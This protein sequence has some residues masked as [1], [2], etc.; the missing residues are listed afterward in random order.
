MWIPKPGKPEKR[1]LGIST[2]RDRC[3][4]ALFKLALEPEWEAIPYGKKIR[5]VLTALD[6]VEHD[7][8]AAIRFL[9]QI[10]DSDLTSWQ[11]RRGC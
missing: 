7:A 8:V 6:L 2:I 4:Q 11:R 5:G 3:L 9:I 10:P 1:P